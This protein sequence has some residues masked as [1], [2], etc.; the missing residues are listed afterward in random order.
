MLGQ[1]DYDQIEEVIHQNKNGNERGKYK[2]YSDKDRFS[3]GKYASQNG[4]AAT[5]QKFK[6]DF[7]NI[8]ES[9]VRG[10]RKKYEKEIA[11]AKKDQ[12]NIPKNEANH[13]C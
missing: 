10:F 1:V 12:R 11:K 6:K 8:N 2:Q 5:V 4:P 13:L 7:K 9:T 3:I